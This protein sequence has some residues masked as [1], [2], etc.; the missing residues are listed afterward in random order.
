MTPTPEAV[1]CRRHGELSHI[2]RDRWS[3]RMAGGTGQAYLRKLKRNG[4]AEESDGMVRLTDFL[5]EGV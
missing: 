5:L 3:G 2:F 1:A 4:L